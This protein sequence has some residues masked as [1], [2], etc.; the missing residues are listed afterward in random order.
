MYGSK[1]SKLFHLTPNC[2][3][4]HIKCP[5][6]LE[7]VSG[8]FGCQ[9]CKASKILPCSACHT[10]TI[11]YVRFK[12]GHSFCNEC[13]NSILRPQ[14]LRRCKTLSC[15]CGGHVE[16]I[17]NDAVSLLLT[18][19]WET[20]SHDN[21]RS[22]ADAFNLS[23]PHCKRV[24]VDFEACLAIRCECD[25]FFCALCLQPFETNEEAH[26]HVLQC[27]LNP[28]RS[29]FMPFEAWLDVMNERRKQVTKTVL[30]ESTGLQNVSNAYDLMRQ[31][32]YINCEHVAWSS[33]IKEFL[34][35]AKN[36]IFQRLE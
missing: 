36:M 11:P 14:I 32:E 27:S 26:E 1:R 5:V 35:F 19:V 12:C 23:C 30:L 3:N 34:W 25:R 31:G 2:T 17:S 4:C 6:L 29:Y 21:Q 10:Q 18:E 33:A 28:N 22:L 7:D 13:T 20:V 24:F 8:K 16:E 15:P 9:K